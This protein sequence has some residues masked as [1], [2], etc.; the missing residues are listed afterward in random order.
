[1]RQL[2]VHRDMKLVENVLSTSSINLSCSR[3]RLKQLLR[4]FRALQTSSVLH[5]SHSASMTD[6]LID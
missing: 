6:L 1:M 5:K 3:L 4:I 2:Y